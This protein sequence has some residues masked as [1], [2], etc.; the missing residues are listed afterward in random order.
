VW[1]GVKE[2]SAVSIQSRISRATLRDLKVLQAIRRKNA[3]LGWIAKGGEDKIDIK[4][5]WGDSEK[6]F[7]DCWKLHCRQYL[8]QCQCC[9]RSW[10][11]MLL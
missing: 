9:V 3:K 2:L 1:A 6:L 8:N 7:V 11:T 4:T 5:V 10:V